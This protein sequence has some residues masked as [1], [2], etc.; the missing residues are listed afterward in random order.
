MITEEFNNGWWG[1]FENFAAELLSVNAYD[2][3]ICTAV[4][5]GAGI[6]KDEASA[7]LDREVYADPKVVEIVRNYWLK[8]KMR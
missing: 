4:L 7:W 3:G 6:T 8:T 1:C 5:K 2:D